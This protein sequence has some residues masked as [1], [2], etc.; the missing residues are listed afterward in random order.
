MVT[1]DAV[2]RYVHDLN[3][4]GK[5]D[6]H[7]VVY[8]S[9]SAGNDANDGLT[10]DAPVAT[11]EAA[12]AKLQQITAPGA[13]GTVILLDTYTI[14]GNSLNL[15]A[16][17]F[18]VLL[19]SKTGAEGFTYSPGGSQPQRYIAFNSETTLENITL[20]YTKTSLSCIKANG[21]KLTIGANVNTV[22]TAGAYLNL[23]GGTYE[24]GKKADSTELIVRSGHWRNIYAGGFN[25]GVTGDVQLHLTNAVVDSNVVSSRAGAT[26]GNVTM[27]FA[28]VTI[29]GGIFAGNS[30]R[31]D[32]LG[33]VTITLGENVSAAN[34]VRA[35][36]STAGNVEGTVTILAAGADLGQLV[37]HGTAA[38]DTGKVGKAVL[39]LA[40]DLP[41]AITVDPNFTLNLNGYDITGNLTVDGT[42]TVY[43]SATDD[44]DV[45]DGRCG[46]I[47][48]TV[49]GNLQAAEG[50]IAAADGFHKLGGQ[51]ISS[52]SLRPQN[53]GIYYT[54]TVLADE[55][56]LAELETGVAVSLADL[57]GA[58]FAT[59][60]DTLYCTGTNSVVI[61]NIL[62]GNAEDPDRAIMDIYAVSYVKL[63]DG[64]VL[65]SDENIAYSLYDVL[66][67]VKDQ[68][69][70][71]FADFCKT[72]NIENWF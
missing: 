29:G 52:V 11:M 1:N 62:K 54:A 58:D 24:D 39:Q 9:Q 65:T 64:T 45:S 34:G 51:Y 14:P 3:E 41:Y 26:G 32:V 40:Q 67:L 63:K 16:C 4:A 25:D 57:P 61:E 47:T 2:Y 17:D 5:L 31:N 71:D 13:V 6:T 55:V 42:L 46:E 22:G 38:N 72:H 15:P 23:I 8:V 33:D 44:Y 28:D 35:G 49:T 7:T 37:L 10:G 48:G 20:T 27:Y 50:Y 56:L 68:Y 70:D 53:A 30:N 12:Y 59:D 19:T 18:Q 69:P 66:L 21:H 60:A 36:S 43:D